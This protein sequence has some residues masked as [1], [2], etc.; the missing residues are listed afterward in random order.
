MRPS[1]VAPSGASADWAKAG[2]QAIRP[3]TS[4]PLVPSRIHWALMSLHQVGV[5]GASDCFRLALDFGPK[6]PAA[7]RQLRESG[8]GR[9]CL[10]W[11]PTA[12]KSND[13]HRRLLRLR[14]EW[15][16]CRCTTDERDK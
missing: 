16:C 15:P 4:I 1:T 6:Y 14:R 2:A 7:P 9:G 8:D 13:R 10:G 11:R 5:D 3:A 12:E